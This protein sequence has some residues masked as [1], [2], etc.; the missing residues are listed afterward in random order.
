MKNW[1]NG[2]YWCF[3]TTQTHAELPELGLVFLHSF[4]CNKIVQVNRTWKLNAYICPFLTLIL[5]KKLNSVSMCLLCDLSL[6]LAGPTLYCISDIA[7]CF[8]NSIF[9][10]FE[11]SCAL[12]SRVQS[13]FSISRKWNTECLLCYLI[14]KITMEKANRELTIVSWHKNWKN[15]SERFCFLAFWGLY[16]VWLRGD[17]LQ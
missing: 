13:S 9:T 15:A 8:P 16:V 6:V 11:I 5:K 17:A 14:Y 12:V 2:C 1:C 4:L 10:V 3:L 7:T